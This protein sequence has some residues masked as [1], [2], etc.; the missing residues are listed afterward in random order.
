MNLRG[1]TLTFEYKKICCSKRGLVGLCMSCI[2]ATAMQ[3]ILNP[4]GGRDSGSTAK[5]ITCKTLWDQERLKDCTAGN[6]WLSFHGFTYGSLVKTSFTKF[7]LTKVSLSVILAWAEISSERVWVFRE[8]PR[9]KRQN[10]SIIATNNHN[11]F[12]CSYNNWK[13]KLPLK[14]ELSNSSCT[15][16]K[17]LLD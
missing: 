17:F 16:K 6:N 2:E 8:E 3:D 7:L 4:E 10:K 9:F 1:T 5:Q 14:T 12:I 11:N 15:P 13:E